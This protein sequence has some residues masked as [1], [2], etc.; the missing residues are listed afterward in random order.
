PARGPYVNKLKMTQVPNWCLEFRIQLREPVCQALAFNQGGF[1]INLTRVP[2]NFEL[3][4]R[5]SQ[6]F[7]EAAI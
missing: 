4:L 2:G 3:G 1:K 5:L 7:F 6:C